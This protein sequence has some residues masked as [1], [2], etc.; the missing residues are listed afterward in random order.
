MEIK[1]VKKVKSN[2]GE[3]EFY[4]YFYGGF[5][6]SFIKEYIKQFRESE[7]ILQLIYKLLKDN[8]DYKA[9]LYEGKVGIE[10]IKTKDYYSLDIEF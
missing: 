6:R 10:N 4:Q 3:I 7:K 5:D 9:T 8:K 1:D 2:M